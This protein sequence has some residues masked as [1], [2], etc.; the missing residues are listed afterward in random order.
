MDPFTADII[1]TGRRENL[2][3]EAENERVVRDVRHRDRAPT[4]QPRPRPRTRPA[5]A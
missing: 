3:R 2:I 1:A 4:P 5:T